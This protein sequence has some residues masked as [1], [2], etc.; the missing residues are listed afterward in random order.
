MFLLLV[1]KR[2][3]RCP[4]LGLGGEDA[5]HGSQR[6]GPELHCPLEGGCQVL[7]A[8]GFQERQHA[9]CLVLAHAM[10]S[11]QALQEAAG[12][13]PQLG[14]ACPQVG[15]ALTSVFLG[16]MLGQLAM[17]TGHAARQQPV[18]GEYL[19]VRAINDQLL[20]RDPQRQHLPQ[21]P[22][23][24]RVEVLPVRHHSFRIDFAVDHFRRVVGLFRNG[25]QIGQLLRVQVE[26]P[27]FR[28]A[29]HTHVGHFRQPLDRHFIEM[30]QR[31][32]LT[33]IEQAGFHKVEGPFHF[34]LRLRPP[35]LHAHTR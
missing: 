21:I 2:F 15:F 20:F 11:Q 26:R 14:E 16:S 22:P 1:T 33:P 34:A 8:I 6:E 32:E 12:G 3:Q 25:D 30:L 31:T 27:A 10:G 19:Q 7:L 5:F 9:V 24:D 35:R 17:L 23:G 4:G 18:P 28:L 29:M 13:R